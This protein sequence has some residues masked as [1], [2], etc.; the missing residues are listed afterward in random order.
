[1]SDLVVICNV[2]F[3][4]VTQAEA[5]ARI[6]EFM[7]SGKQHQIVTA[8]PEFTL[9]AQKNH[10]FRNVLYRA[11]LS[12]PDGIGILWASTFLYILPNIQSKLLQIIIFPIEIIISLSSLMLYPPLS[13]KIFKE[14]VTGVD[15]FQSISDLSRQKSWS[16]FFLGGQRG[17][18]SKA[19][20]E[21][22]K[23]YP[24]VEVVGYY[25]GS[26]NV[27][28]EAEII[29]EINN[30]RPDILFVAYG[31]PSQEFWISRN[32]SKLRTVKVAMGI[33]GSFDMVAGEKKRSPVYLQKIGLEWLWRLIHEP[34]RFK[35]IYNATIQFVI[36][37]IKE[38]VKMSKKKEVEFKF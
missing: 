15:L 6:T 20:R 26:P 9:E 21:I 25:A 38:K 35:R 1:M 19:K 4:R 36:L 32:L 23:K 3:H 12:V 22:E 5:L 28:D 34:K 13:R 27:G 33:G 8:N 14:R 24:G 37:V 16:L 30:A 29:Q 7:H 18:A 31:A 2:P 17:I 10:L 11:S